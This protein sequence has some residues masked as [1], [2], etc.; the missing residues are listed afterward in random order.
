LLILLF[1]KVILFSVFGKRCEPNKNLKYFTVDDFDGLNKRPI[2]FKSNKGQTLKGNIYIYET[3]KDYK[4]LIVFVHG[5]GGGHLSYTTEINTF[6]KAGFAV[7]S[8]DNTGTW[9]SE[10][11]NLKGFFQSVIDLKYALKFVS[12]DESLNNYNVYLVGHSWGAYSV[13]Q[14]LQY[15]PKV[16]KVVALSGFNNSSKI[17]CDTMKEQTKVNCSFLK[18]F[19]TAINFLNFGK[20]AIKNTVNIL[21]ETDIPV[22]IL[23]GEADTSVTLENSLCNKC[24]EGKSNIKI[25]SYKERYHNVYQTKESE[26]YLNDTFASLSKLKKQY[27][28]KIPKEEID[29]IYN[30]IDYYKMTEESQEVMDMIIKFIEE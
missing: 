8:Y 7:M 15:N 13:C 5:M 18:P 24:L 6:A 19:F 26:K 10:G 16:K 23:Q 17:I 20:D 12:E 9:E 27:K 22:L 21:K 29:K 4:G 14:V 28:G 30:N 25:I 1:A 11:K 3:I 2:Q